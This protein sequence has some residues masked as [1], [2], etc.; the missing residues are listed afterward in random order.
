MKN[1]ELIVSTENTGNVIALN[2][3]AI[4]LETGG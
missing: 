1:I 2:V 3:L 4:S